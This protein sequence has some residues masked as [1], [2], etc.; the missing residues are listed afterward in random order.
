MNIVVIDRWA[1]VQFPSWG[2]PSPSKLNTLN[3]ATAINTSKVELE[4]TDS[5]TKETLIEQ[6]SVFL[7]DGSINN[8]NIRAGRDRLCWVEGEFS[9]HGRPSSIKTTPV[10]L[11]WQ[12][13]NSNSLQILLL[14]YTQF[15]WIVRLRDCCY[16]LPAPSGCVNFGNAPQVGELPNIGT[17]LNDHASQM[18][19]R[20][21]QR[22]LS[23]ASQHDQTDVSRRLP[24]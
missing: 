15:L 5:P 23:P 21:K 3:S 2:H 4:Q 10:P 8:S 9:R 1:A 7:E 12:N 24:S 13:W 18:V 6:A 22:K 20:S 16:C 11:K 17:A 14:P 19:S